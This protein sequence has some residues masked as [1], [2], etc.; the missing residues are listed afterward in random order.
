MTRLNTPDGLPPLRDVIAAYGLQA[1]KKF[2]QNFILDLNLTRRIAR[3]AGPLNDR[4]VVEVGAGPGGLTRALLLEGAAKVI[5]IERDHRCLPALGDI[6]SHYPGRLIVQE[7]D[8]AKMEWQSLLKG[9]PGK[10]IIAANLPYAI[11]TLLLVDW[12]EAESWPP[13]WDRMAL[14]FQKEVGERLV[15]HPGTKAYGRLAVLAQWRTEARVAM[16]LKP[17][18]FVPPPKVESSVVVLIPRASPEPACSVAALARVTAAAFGQRRKMLRS[19]LKTLTP[20][21]ELLLQSAGLDP[22][23]RAEQVPVAGF[24]RLADAFG[25]SEGSQL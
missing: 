23:L 25:R 16:T 21:P 12:L 22:N 19:S 13:W 8:A 3:T 10:A 11:A 14:M 1:K 5:A 2:S 15:A 9:C 17:S 24:A 18:A 4:W 6:A 20:F 7:G